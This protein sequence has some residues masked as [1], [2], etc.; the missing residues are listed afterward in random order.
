M[1]LVRKQ[2]K[3]ATSSH[4]DLIQAD[5]TDGFVIED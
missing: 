3:K 4:T 5:F 2:L 1:S